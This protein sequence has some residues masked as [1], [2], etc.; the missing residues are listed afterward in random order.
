M[1]ELAAAQEKLAQALGLALA[2]PVALAKAGA[3]VDDAELRD[4]LLH[5]GYEAKEAR[6]RCLEVARGWGDE[7]AT[8]IV[9]RAHSYE[10]KAGETLRAW[11]RPATTALERFEVLAMAEAAEVVTWRSLALLGAGDPALAELVEWGVPV[12]ERHFADA[13]EACGVLAQRR[14][15]APG[16]LRP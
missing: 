14:V 5:M 12:Q 10:D 1:P 3:E 2:A 15:R 7:V 16:S 11:V 4:L 9:Q 13:V 8:E 6:A